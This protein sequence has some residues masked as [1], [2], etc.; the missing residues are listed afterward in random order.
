MKSF[1]LRNVSFLQV[2]QSHSKEQLL[3]ACSKAPDDTKALET[4]LKVKMVFV[5]KNT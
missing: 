1:S 2:S 5:T 3:W 4:T